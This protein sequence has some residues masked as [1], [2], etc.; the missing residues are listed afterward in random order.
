MC[1]TDPTTCTCFH[2]IYICQPALAVNVHKQIHTH[3]LTDSERERERERPITQNNT[4][5]Q[6][7]PVFKELDR[8]LSLGLIPVQEGATRNGLRVQQ[9]FG[10][11]YLKSNTPGLKKM[12]DGK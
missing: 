2:N 4:T 1:D 5:F 8:N 12:V 3:T 10:S 7:E 11:F 6:V 9:A